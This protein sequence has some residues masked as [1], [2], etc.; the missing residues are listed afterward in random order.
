MNHY[1]K[2]YTDE[3][4]R[5]VVD[6][7]LN[8]TNNSVPDIMKALGYNESFTSNTIDRYFKEKI[9]IKNKANDTIPR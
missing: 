6:Y 3:D 9:R 7:F 2:I 1:T 5:R 4:K 8:H